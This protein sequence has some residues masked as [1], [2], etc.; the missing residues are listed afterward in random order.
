MVRLLPRILCS[1]SLSKE[2]SV[3]RFAFSQLGA[4]D[5]RVRDKVNVF[6]HV[7]ANLDILDGDEIIFNDVL[8]PVAELTV[9][10]KSG[11]PC[12]M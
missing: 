1:G 11:N 9:A 12:P 5:L 2:D 7:E 3:L 6:V 10:Q 4:P 8:F